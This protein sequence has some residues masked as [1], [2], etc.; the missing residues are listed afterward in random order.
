MI[1][2]PNLLFISGSGKKVGKTYLVCKDIKFQSDLV[3]RM[4][5][6]N[7]D[8]DIDKIIYQD[9]TWKINKL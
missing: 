6:N 8:F 1:E 2:Y 7:F 9:K 4:N 3:I 5:E